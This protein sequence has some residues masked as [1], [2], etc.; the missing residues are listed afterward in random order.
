MANIQSLLGEQYKEGMTN[1]EIV[2]ALENVELPQ[3]KSDEVARL[4]KAFD[5]TASEAAEYKR[6]LKAHMS[7]EEKKSA[8][9]A[10]KYSKME[11]ENAALRKQVALSDLTSKFISSGLDAE[12]AFKTAEA[13]YSGDFDTVIANFSAHVETATKTAAE[14]AKA[15]LLAQNPV[16]KGG[17]TA[18]QVKDYS[19]DIDSALAN[20]D[21]ANAAALMRM[22]Q[23]QT[24][25]TNN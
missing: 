12:T 10:E 4:K 21:Y 8:E 18:P 6:Q 3:D 22:Q 7:E 25:I 11:E 2:A 23:E 15:E 20:G 19:K 5:K 9:E 1:D 24:N 14:T 16:M 17:R 13:A